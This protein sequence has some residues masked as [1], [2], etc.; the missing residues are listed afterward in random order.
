MDDVQ[1]TIV[2]SVLLFMYNTC[3]CCAAFETDPAVVNIKSTNQQYIFCAFNL[4]RN[5]PEASRINFQ[6]QNNDL[7]YNLI[8]LHALISIIS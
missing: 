7:H 4:L 3:S 8:F 5:K 1:N 2:L 6:T